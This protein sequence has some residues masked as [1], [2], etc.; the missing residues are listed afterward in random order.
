MLKAD[1]YYSGEWNNRSLTFTF[2]LVLSNEFI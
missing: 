1:L 2:N